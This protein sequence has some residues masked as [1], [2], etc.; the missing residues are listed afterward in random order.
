[1]KRER[2]SSR[3]TFY[4]RFVLPCLSIGGVGAAIGAL[5]LEKTSPPPLGLKV[6]LVATWVALGVV[7][8]RLARSLRTVWLEGDHLVSAN[9]REEL[10]IPLEL[11][12]QVAAT[13]YW[14]PERIKLTLR[15]RS[16]LPG[17]LVFA[18][19]YRFRLAPFKEHPLAG[20]LRS[21]VEEAKGREKG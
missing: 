6:A 3:W 20:R 9:F 19:R 12:D 2:L 21:L 14:D 18:A 11:V 5:L 13:R 1:M 10:R 7:V 16:D 17:E 15:P 4:Y 8:L